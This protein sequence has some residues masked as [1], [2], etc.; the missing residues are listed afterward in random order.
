MISVVDL[1]TKSND[2]KKNP[3]SRMKA[4]EESEDVITSIISPLGLLSCPLCK[5]D[6]S[7]RSGTLNK[8]H[9]VGKFFVKFLFSIL[10]VYRHMEDAHGIFHN[11]DSLLTMVF[12]EPFEKQVGAIF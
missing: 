11:I 6:I 2:M 10:Q 7:L 1:A 12:L 4:V 5:A 3:P 9:I 8:V